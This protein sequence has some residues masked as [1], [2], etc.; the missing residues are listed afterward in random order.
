MHPFGG[1]LGLGGPSPQVCEGRQGNLAS[2]PWPFAALVRC[3]SPA[4]KI[5]VPGRTIWLET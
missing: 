5:G 4:S 1:Q 3:P 2:H